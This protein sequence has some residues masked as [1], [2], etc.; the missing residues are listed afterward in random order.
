MIKEF[1]EQCRTDEKRGLL[2]E[3]YTDN[4]IKQMGIKE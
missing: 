3:G 1:I 2:D 4:I